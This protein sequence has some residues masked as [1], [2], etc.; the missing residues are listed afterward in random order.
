[1]AIFECED[2]C[3]ELFEDELWFSG[4]GTLSLSFSDPLVISCGLRL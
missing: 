1:M 3:D 2:R 4:N